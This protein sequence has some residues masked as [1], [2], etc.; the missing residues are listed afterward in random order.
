MELKQSS[1]SVVLKGR[2]AVP[3]LAEGKALVCPESIAGWGGIDPKTG[4]IKEYDNSNRGRTI[5]NTILVMPGS[6]GSNGW[7]CYFN[8]AGV[9]GAGPLGLIFTRIDSSAAVAATLLKIP[10]V[11]DFDDS[12][13]PCRHIQTGDRV[14]IN[15]TTGE[16]AI[17]KQDANPLH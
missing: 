4:I 13:D 16:V 15:G 11:V 14:R 5:H 10:T 9:A 6:R 2:G 3:G 7:S 12:Q 17:L 8:A 1:Q